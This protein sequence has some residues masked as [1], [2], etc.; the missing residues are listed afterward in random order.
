MVGKPV[1]KTRSWEDDIKNRARLTRA[2][3]RVNLIVTE[4]S[5]GKVYMALSPDGVLELKKSYIRILE[6][7]TVLGWIDGP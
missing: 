5:G 1:R 2:L 7:A 3:R 6:R 4:R